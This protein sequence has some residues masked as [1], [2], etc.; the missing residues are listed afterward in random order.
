MSNTVQPQQGSENV[1][2]FLFLFPLAS[3]PCPLTSATATGCSEN[4]LLSVQYS[5]TENT[6]FNAKFG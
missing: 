2:L 4:A 6:M 5:S 1:C 3:V